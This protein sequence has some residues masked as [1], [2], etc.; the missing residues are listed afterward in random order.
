M[1]YRCHQAGLLRETRLYTTP[2]S[3]LCATSNEQAIFAGG[4]LAG[5]NSIQASDLSPLKPHWSYSE[6]RRSHDMVGSGKYVYLTTDLLT[7]SY[8]TSKTAKADQ[9]RLNRPSGL[10]ARESDRA[11]AICM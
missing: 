1:D 6:L 5:L 10:I 7:L 9:D 8:S 4:D 2:S 11:A 3:V